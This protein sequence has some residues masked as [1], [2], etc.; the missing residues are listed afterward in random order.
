MNDFFVRNTQDVD[1]QSI[2]VHVVKGDID[3]VL[4]GLYRLISASSLLSACE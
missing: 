2:L 4:I 1:L 3:E